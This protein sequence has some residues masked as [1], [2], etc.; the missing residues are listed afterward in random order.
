M[1]ILPKQLHTSAYVPDTAVL[2]SDLAEQSQI[3]ELSLLARSKASLARTWSQKWNRD[4]WTQHLSGR[5]LKPSHGQT[6][7]TAWTSSL[8]V[9]PASHS[10][11]Q[12]SDSDE[13]IHDTSGLGSQM[14]LELCDLES[15]SLRTSK[16]TSASDLERSSKNWKALVT[17]RRGE[18]SQR[19]KSAHLTSASES[20]SWASITAN[21]WKGSTPNSITRKDGKSRIDQLAYQTEQHGLFYPTPCAMEAEKAGFHNKGQMGQS[22]SAMAKRGEL[23]QADPDNSSTDGSRQ[24]SWGTPSC[25]DTLPARSPEALARAKL[26]GGCKNLREEVHQWPTATA[27]DWKMGRESYRNRREGV[28]SSMLPSAVKDMNQWATPRTGATDNSR[29]N[30]KGGIPLGDQARRAEP[31]T[32]PTICAGDYRTPPTNSGTTGQAIMPASE[33]ALPKAAG[34]KLN[35]RWVETLMG[36]P[37]GWTMP[38][39][40]SPVTIVPTNC[41]FLETE[42][43]QLLQPEL[44]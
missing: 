24:E 40:A 33:H 13:K 27:S 14:E 2:I 19:V 12:A 3:C 38:S 10:Q 6:F 31:T 37:V 5:I 35:P 25:M 29:P 32:W 7:V 42:L 9:I 28:M 1:W 21:D 8:E 11:Q 22:L 43:C 18:Y 41:D 17:I 20:L 15:A 36:L 39:C 30:N 34:G 23:G 16:D 44:F 26:K 4:S